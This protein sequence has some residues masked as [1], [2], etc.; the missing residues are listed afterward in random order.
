MF[1]RALGGGFTKANGPPGDDNHR[2]AHNVRKPSVETS[3]LKDV[4]SR[5]EL[6]LGISPVARLHHNAH[7]SA[8]GKDSFKRS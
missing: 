6:G 3:S 1:E 7:G 2:N 8:T 5:A 4:S